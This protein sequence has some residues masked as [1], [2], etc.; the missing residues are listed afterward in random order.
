MRS[1][2]RSVEGLLSDMSE[3]A[4][5]SHLLTVRAWLIECGFS[6]VWVRGLDSRSLLA[7]ALSMGDLTVRVDTQ[8]AEP[9]TGMGVGHATARR[10]RDAD[11]RA[12]LG[13]P[14]GGV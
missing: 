5:E 4:S 12:A 7:A 2:L 6:E 1:E 8:S 13:L 9:P 10:D 11:A 14:P 3:I